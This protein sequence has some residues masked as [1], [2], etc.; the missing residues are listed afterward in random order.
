MFKFYI[1]IIINHLYQLKL[2]NLR[3]IIEAKKT[4][5]NYCE[6]SPK[7]LYCRN[8]TLF[9][10]IL[11]ISLLG[12]IL[13]IIYLIISCI[14]KSRKRRNNSRDR[15]RRIRA[16]S[17]ITNRLENEN[18]IQKKISYLFTKELIPTF[19]SKENNNKYNICPV[20]LEKYIEGSEICITPCKHCF[21]YI[22]IR[23]YAIMTKNSNCPICKFDFLSILDG[24][25]INY[26]NIEIITLKSNN[27]DIDKNYEGI[28]E[29]NYVGSSIV[30]DDNI[31][32]IR[33]DN[34]D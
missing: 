32:A 9:Y 23:N 20:C 25:N 7:S 2:I 17:L 19:F 8:R 16:Y 30:N 15:T 29:N 26:N 31:I 33:N 5:S 12:T 34:N 3:K 22:C 4:S 13:G 27:T 11:I 28:Q 24:K 14:S 18:L 1:I 21:H 6:Q 10:I